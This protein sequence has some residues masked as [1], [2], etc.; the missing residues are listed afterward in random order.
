MDAYF[1]EMFLSE[2]LEE[3]EKISCIPTTR[4]YNIIYNKPFK[5]LWRH[6][7]FKHLEKLSYI[8]TTLITIH[9]NNV[10]IMQ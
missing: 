6:K 7:I 5:I 9:Q 2:K 4:M 1:F 8:Q 3:A 10:K